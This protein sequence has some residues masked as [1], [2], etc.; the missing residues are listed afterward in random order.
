VVL[1][2]RTFSS[3]EYRY[4]FNGKELDNEGMG[5]G[6]QTYDYGFRI[7]NP[8]LAKFLSVDPLLKNYAWNSPFSFAEND[9]LRGVDLDGLE[10]YYAGDG[11]LLGHFDGSSEIRVVTATYLNSDRY[12]NINSYP[13]FS[14]TNKQW[15]ERNSTALHTHHSSVISSVFTAIFKAKLKDNRKVHVYIA[16]GYEG[17]EHG[18]TDGKISINRN[19]NAAIDGGSFEIDNYC[20]VVAMLAHE[21]LHDDYGGDYFSHFIISK[22]VYEGYVKGK[23]VTEAFKGYIKGEMRQY[24]DGMKGTLTDILCRAHD[25]EISQQ[26][27]EKNVALFNGL[28]SDYLNAVD[29]YNKTYGENG[30]AM[31]F[32]TY[33]KNTFEGEK[34]IITN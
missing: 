30:K 33:E 8:S 34:T 5:G 23:D 3:E 20:N 4:G 25:T 17:A 2:G 1:E 10:Y 29:Y 24:I 27:R 11:S 15:Y 18:H 14:N 9:V 19:F 13:P 12:P 28:C 7:Y 31:D 6:N 22:K 16:P 32:K 26:E 21:K